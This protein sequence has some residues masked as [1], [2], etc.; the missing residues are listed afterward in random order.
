MFSPDS[1]FIFFDTHTQRSFCRCSCFSSRPFRQRWCM[2]SVEANASASNLSENAS[3]KCREQ[4]QRAALTFP[5][6]EKA[7]PADDLRHLRRYHLVPTLV[8]RCDTFEH[9][10]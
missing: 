6:S 2:G 3:C 9:V 5:V 10:A 4:G 7:T 1:I 8:A